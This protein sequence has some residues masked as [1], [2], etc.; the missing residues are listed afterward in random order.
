M[1]TS[2]WRTWLSASVL[3]P[4]VASYVAY[5]Q[6]HGYSDPIAGAYLRAVGHFAHWLTD[7]HLTLRRVDELV[8]HRFVTS[9]LPA[10]RCP[11]RCQR[12]V[13]VVQAALGHLL[14][15]LRA[16]GRITARR[17]EMSGAIHDELERFASHLE[18]VCGLAA[19][20]RASR[21]WW[22]GQFL[23]DR[24]GR[25]PIAVDR[26]T[27]RGIV[28]FLVRDAA[29]Y[30]PG[31]AG[32]R[33]C[34]LRSYFRFRAARCA[35][36]VDALIAAIPSVAC[37]RLATLPSHL[38][39]DETARF[40]NAFDRRQANGQRGYAMARCLV[41]LG[42]R[43]SE[44]ATLQLDDLHW[45]DGTV[46]IGAGKS[47]RA[48][49]LPLPVLTGRAIV[50]YLRHARPPSTSRAVFVRHRAP[51]DAPITTEIVRYAGRSAFVRCGLGARSTG[52][53]ILRRTMATQMRCAGASLKQIADVLP[54]RSLDTT[55]IYTKI[56]RP[57]LATV[58]AAWP[59][60]G[61][62]IHGV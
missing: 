41:D 55:T 50:E 59:G 7:E 18:Q 23:A 32:V 31:T 46:R 9:H 60:G 49:V 5:L 40:L 1:F 22:V 28:D 57:Q 8:V 27:P 51:L 37:W 48:D 19:K 45:Q 42:L 26:L 12:T 47:R 3:K 15:V 20:T 44:V 58:A 62:A 61:P 35:D 33:G 56:D 38:T 2:P 13:I 30:T 54:R 21:R 14:D 34:A 10:C 4:S 52:T 17:V 24:F 36:R 53:H 43:A 25:G 39:P 16:D 29:R 6:R 11:G